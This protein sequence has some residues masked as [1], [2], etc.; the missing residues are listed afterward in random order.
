MINSGIKSKISSAWS[1]DRLQEKKNV[2]ASD[3][4]TSQGPKIPEVYFLIQIRYIYISN[5]TKTVVSYVHIM[6]DTTS[7]TSSRKRYFT[8]L[9]VVLVCHRS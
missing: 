5:N 7:Y 1:Q 2:A 6:A 3:E 4:Y 8:C 9:S